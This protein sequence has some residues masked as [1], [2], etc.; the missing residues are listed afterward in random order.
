MNELRK[1]ILQIY[2]IYK[3]DDLID[4]DDLE[5]RLKAERD[6]QIEAINEE[7]AKLLVPLHDLCIYLETDNREAEQRAIMALTDTMLRELEDAADEL[8]IKRVYDADAVDALFAGYA[9]PKNITA[10]DQHKAYARLMLRTLR[11]K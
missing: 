4:A 1:R 2:D 11:E 6:A 10:E 8:Q 5:R 7:Y 3:R 9:D